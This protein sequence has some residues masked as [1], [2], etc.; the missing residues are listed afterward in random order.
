MFY[1]VRANLLFKE[2]D[3]AWN[4]YH[5]CQLAIVKSD[6]I[7]PDQLNMEFGTIELLGNNHDQDPAESCAVIQLADNK[8]KPSL[9]GTPPEFLP[10]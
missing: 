6:I 7:N 10:V 2:R 1:Q 4:F 8:P 5:D 3:E 9:D